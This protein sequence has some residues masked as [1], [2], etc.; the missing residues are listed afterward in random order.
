MVE[1]SIKYWLLWSCT[2][3]SNSRFDTPPYALMPAALAAQ[4]DEVESSLVIVR[5]SAAPARRQERIL[6]RQ[7]PLGRTCLQHPKNAF[8]TN[9]V[10]RPLKASSDLRRSVPTAAAQST[11]IAHPSTTQVASCSCKKFSEAL[12]SSEEPS[13]RQKALI[14]HALA[15]RTQKVISKQEL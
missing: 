7:K 8:Q 3:S 9:Q 6:L 14:K 2:R 13:W 5:A 15:S 4:H 1:S 11:S 10:A 12:T